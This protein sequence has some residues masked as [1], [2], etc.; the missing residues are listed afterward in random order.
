MLIERP[1]R[2]SDV[3]GREALR[4]WFFSGNKRRILSGFGHP[5]FVKSSRLE[6]LPAFTSVGGVCA[7]LSSFL[8]PFLH[9]ATY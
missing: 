8:Q 6:Q 7:S 5:E 4:G 9:F 2:D 1:E 3:C